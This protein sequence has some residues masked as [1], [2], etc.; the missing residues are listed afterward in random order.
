MGFDFLFGLRI[1]D[2]LFSCPFLYQRREEGGDGTGAD[3]PN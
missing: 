3:S 1:I 2:P